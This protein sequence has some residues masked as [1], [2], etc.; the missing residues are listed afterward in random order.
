MTKSEL[1]FALARV[2][3]AVAWADGEIAHEELNALKELL[4]RLP[5]MEARDWARLEIYMETPVSAAE[6]DRLLHELR[7][8]LASPA[9]KRL[10]REA[11][12]GLVQADGILS[13]EEQVLVSQ[14]QAAI[15]A[16][17]VSLLG[18]AGRLLRAALGLRGSSEA[19][20]REAELE[21]FLR[22]RVYF[23]L[24][25]RLRSSAETL[26]LD[27]AQLR[28]LSLAGGLLAR[29]AHADHEVTEGE[30]QAIEKVLREHWDLDPLQASLVVDIA[31]EVAG[32]ELDEFRLTRS[33]FDRTSAQERQSFVE[34][35]F[36][37][38]AADGL[39]DRHETE[40]IR[41]IAQGLKLTHRQFI[42]AKLTLPARKR[43]D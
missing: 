1:I 14:I 22:N 15:E 25:H 39:A 21:D 31:L 12:E 28:K 42:Q 32:R 26:P 24:R 7:D 43:A 41:R 13:P 35:L 17:D 30:R 10:V 11:L 33:F 9:D 8:K 23:N 29:V 36:H 18:K 4:L 38:A 40:A 20:D 34:A 6:R 5:R 3:I 16:Q 2:L 37:V 27:E 19:P